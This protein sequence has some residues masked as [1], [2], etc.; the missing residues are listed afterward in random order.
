VVLTANSARHARSLADDLAQLCS[1][2]SWE[3]RNREGYSLGQWILLDLNDVVINIFLD[4][5]REIYRLESLWGCD[6][7]ETA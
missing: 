7:G 3:Y 5:A 1:E 4:A 6:K 2:R